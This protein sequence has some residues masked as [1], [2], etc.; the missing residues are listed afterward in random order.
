MDGWMDG[1][2]LEGKEGCTQ[3]VYCGKRPVAVMKLRIVGPWALV[4]SKEDLVKG[5]G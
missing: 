1:W 3:L 2:M 5:F 4:E